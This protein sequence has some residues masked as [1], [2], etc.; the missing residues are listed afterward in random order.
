MEFA[1]LVRFAIPEELTNLTRWQAAMRERARP[2]RPALMRLALAPDGMTLALAAAALQP[3][4][5]DEPGMAMPAAPTPRRLPAPHD[6]DLA[7]R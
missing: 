6:A 4:R 2:G 3:T 1:R 7:D 5:L